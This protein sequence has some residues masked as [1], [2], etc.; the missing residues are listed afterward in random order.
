MGVEDSCP[1]PESLSFDDS[2]V[3]FLVDV[4]DC[5][6]GSISSFELVDELGDVDD[7]DELDVVSAAEHE[8]LKLS[9]TI[10]KTLVNIIKSLC[11]KRI[12][13]NILKW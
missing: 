13:K 12:Y 4:S 6:V 7:L 5:C 11:I 1:A 3:S 8:M 2:E 10:N 9:K